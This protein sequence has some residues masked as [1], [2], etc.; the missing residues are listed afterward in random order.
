MTVRL[1]PGARAV[2]AKPRASPPAKAAWPNENMA[3]LQT[4]EIV[5]RNPQTIYGSVAMAFPKGSNSHR[6]VTDYRPAIDTIEPAD[7]P[8]PSLEDKAPPFVG[9]TTWCTLDMLQGY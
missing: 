9:A 4:A 5:F 7:T 8:M 3:N 2:Q 6:M 1:Q